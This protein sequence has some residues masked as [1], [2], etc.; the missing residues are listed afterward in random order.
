MVLSCGC[1]S[2]GRLWTGVAGGGTWTG[3]AGGESLSIWKPQSGQK[4]NPGVSSAPQ[5]E[6][7]DATRAPQV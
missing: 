5:F 1:V 2:G 6:Q 7:A 4:R 3:V